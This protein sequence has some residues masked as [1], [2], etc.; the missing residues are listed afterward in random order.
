MLEILKVRTHLSTLWSSTSY[1]QRSLLSFRPGVRLS[2][3]V[4]R[5]VVHMT[6]SKT[7]EPHF[8]NLLIL[9]ENYWEIYQIKMTAEFS[10][11]NSHQR[12]QH[13]SRKYFALACSK[14]YLVVA[15]RSRATTIYVVIGAR[16]PETWEK[17]S[18]FLAPEP[19][20]E[21]WYHNQT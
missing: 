16:K 20:L 8:E 3:F 1:F 10:L 7:L 2:L 18:T 5:Y 12:F 14:V 4:F 21:K 19:D 6:Y 9:A 11:K 17:N 15:R 13:N